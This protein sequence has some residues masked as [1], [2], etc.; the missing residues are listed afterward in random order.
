MEIIINKNRLL[1]YTIY[2]N[3]VTIQLLCGTVSIHFSLVLRYIER[4]LHSLGNDK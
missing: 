2:H 1:T 3:I 4:F